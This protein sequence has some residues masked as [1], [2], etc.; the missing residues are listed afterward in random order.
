MN[1]EN[2]YNNIIAEKK[3]IL[4]L[5]WLILIWLTSLYSKEIDYTYDNLKFSINSFLNDKLSLW[6]YESKRDVINRIFLATNLEVWTSDI[7]NPDFQML[8]WQKIRQNEVSSWTKIIQSLILWFLY[9]YAYMATIIKVRD[10]YMPIDSRSFLTFSLASWWMVLVNWF[11]PWSIVY[12]ES[13]I[14]AGYVVFLYF[15]NKLKWNEY[16]NKQENKIENCK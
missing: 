2:I 15:R 8:L 11:I 12:A 1:L 13:F 3:F 14:L 10:Q 5:I 7:T 16:I 9:L 4:I 6:L